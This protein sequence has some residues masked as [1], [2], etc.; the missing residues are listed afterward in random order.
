MNASVSR[1][2]D[3]PRNSALIAAVEDVPRPVT[4]LCVEWARN[5]KASMREV[6]LTPLQMLMPKSGALTPVGTAGED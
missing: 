6:V 2:K 1:R 5:T 3:S 4:L